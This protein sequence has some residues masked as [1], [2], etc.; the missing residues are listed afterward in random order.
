MST[1]K[2]IYYFDKIDI[3]IIAVYKFE[4]YHNFMIFLC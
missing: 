2:I 3:C 4:I 1:Q